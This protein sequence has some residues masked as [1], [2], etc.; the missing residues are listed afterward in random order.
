MCRCIAGS[1]HALHSHQ[2]AKP[3]PGRALADGEDDAAGGARAHQQR[4]QGLRQA[5]RLRRRHPRPRAR[6]L[7]L[8]RR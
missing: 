2:E 1:G 4:V 5:E 7:A 3:G 6:H 8:R